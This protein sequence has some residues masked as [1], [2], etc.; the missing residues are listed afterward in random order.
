M[1]IVPFWLIIFIIASKPAVQLIRDER[2]DIPIDVLRCR[3]RPRLVVT[4]EADELLVEAASELDYRL[5][6]TV[7]P[8]NIAV[9]EAGAKRCERRSSPIPLP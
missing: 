6:K 9:A 4:K 7:V 8:E 3:Y 5:L 1:G 2:H